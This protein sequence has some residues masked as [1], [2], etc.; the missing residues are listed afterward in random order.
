MD[1]LSEITGSPKSK[2]AA[3]NDKQ[4]VIDD[5]IN[6]RH[7]DKEYNE[8]YK[9]WRKQAAAQVNIFLINGLY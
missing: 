6:W 7:Q 3:D 9:K 2:S 4:L 5:H 8:S 1:K